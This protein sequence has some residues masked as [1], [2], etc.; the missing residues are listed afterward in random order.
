MSHPIRRP[1]VQA[2][3]EAYTQRV[4]AAENGTGRVIVEFDFKDGRAI[5]YRPYSEGTRR[6]LNGPNGTHG[7][8]TGKPR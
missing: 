4:L 7:G 1:D 6:S 2:D 8:L 5:S 3:I